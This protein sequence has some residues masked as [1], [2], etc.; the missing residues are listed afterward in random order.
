MP[1]PY[2]YRSALVAAIAAK[3]EEKFLANGV[4]MSWLN[5]DGFPV[6]GKHTGCILVEEDTINQP[7]VLGNQVIELRPHFILKSAFSGGSGSLL[8]AYDVIEF[9]EGYLIKELRL[10]GITGVY[11]GVELTNALTGM[12]PAGR[13][14]I[15]PRQQQDQL[16]GFVST[17][18]FKWR[19]Y[20]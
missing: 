2:S 16:I 4:T 17:M 9:L 10:S 5:Y 19:R 11:R 3:L 15:S 7:D 8:E 20:A 14:T 13:V 18:Q 6:A 1:I 12:E